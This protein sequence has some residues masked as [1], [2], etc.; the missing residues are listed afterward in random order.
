MTRSLI[1]RNPTVGAV[2]DPIEAFFDDMDQI[3]SSFFPDIVF[4]N[5][6]KTLETTPVSNL[7]ID[8]HGNLKYEIAAT[9][10]SPEEI[11]VSIEDGCLVITGSHKE[12]KDASQDWKYVHHRLLTKNFRKVL[13][14]PKQVDVDNTRASVKEGMISVIIPIKK[15][16]V[17][18]IEIKKD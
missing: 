5:F 9:S 10:F 2:S 4:T 17:K 14:I 12:E 13:S 3:F 11:D 8:E 15:K 7:L 18:K 1:R 16:E 6:T